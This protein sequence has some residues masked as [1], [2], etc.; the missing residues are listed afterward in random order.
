[1]FLPFFPVKVLLRVLKDFLPL[2]SWMCE[3]TQMGG[4]GK[5]PPGLAPIRRLASPLSR[6]WSKSFPRGDRYEGGGGQGDWEKA[7]LLGPK[8]VV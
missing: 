5:L 2:V 6:P 7:D 3:L 1:M 4:G 8:L